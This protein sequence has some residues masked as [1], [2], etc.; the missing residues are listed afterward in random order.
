[1]TTVNT[2]TV[3]SGS[4]SR[5]FDSCGK[6]SVWFAATVSVAT[7]SQPSSSKSSPIFSALDRP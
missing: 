1:M 2:D 4:R 6:K 3:T 7:T 5:S